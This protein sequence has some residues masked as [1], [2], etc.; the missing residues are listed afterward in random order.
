MTSPT[1]SPLIIIG[2]HRSGTSMMTQLLESLGLFMG[3]NKDDNHEAR[4]FRYAD[5]WILRQ[6]GGAWDYPEPVAL[7]MENTAVRQLT[8]QY[9][10]TLMKTPYVVR[11]LGLGHYLRWHNPHNLPFAWGWKDPRATFTLPIW[12]DLFPQAKVLHIMRH[13]VDVAHSLQVRH[14]KLIT[15]SQKRLSERPFRYTL[16]W[17][18]M[19]RGGGFTNT[20]RCANLEGGFSLW[21]AY[22]QQ[23]HTYVTNLGSQAMEVR[24]EDFLAEPEKNLTAVAQFC[25]LLS[26]STDQIQ[27]LSNQ[28]Q[29]DRAYAYRQKPD[30]VAFAHKMAPQLATWGYEERKK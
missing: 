21:E 4:F 30:L 27:A 12:L 17:W 15:T 6:S 28:V 23:A 18:R 7:L 11:Y 19:R 9:L 24:Y 16:S 8:V 29:P 14:H 20:L 13:G 1:S 5:E 25:G 10:Q 22:V 26:A 2:M 3:V